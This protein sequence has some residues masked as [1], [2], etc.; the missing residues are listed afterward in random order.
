MAAASGGKHLAFKTDYR[1]FFSDDNPQMLAF[2]ALE[3][4]YTKNDNVMFILAPKDGNA[5]GKETLEAVKTL[6]E[7]A[8]RK[9]CAARQ[10][11]LDSSVGRVA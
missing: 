7:K 2:D 6:T 5:F 8:W 11:R 4:T 3:A 1:V 9:R 10:T